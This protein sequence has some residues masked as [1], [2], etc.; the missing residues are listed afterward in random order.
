MQEIHADISLRDL[1]LILRRGFPLI[2]VAA[3]LAGAAAFVITSILPKS[4]RSTSVVQVIP[5]PIGEQQIGGL[6]FNPR[7]NLSFEAYRSIA[8]DTKVLQQTLDTLEGSDLG[9]SGLK[10]RIELRRLAG[11]DNP[12]QIAPLAVEHLVSDEDPD[13]VLRIASAWSQASLD[14]VRATLTASL[15]AMADTTSQ[16]LQRRQRA[17]DEG[18][19]AWQAFQAGDNRDAIR[20]RLADVNTRFT[21]SSARIDQLGRLIAV[22]RARQAFLADQ[23]E[24][25]TPGT[26]LDTGAQLSA[27]VENR[28]LSSEVATQLRVLLAEQPDFAQDAEQ[29]LLLLLLRAE[30]QQVTTA[31]V[32]QLAERDFILGEAA[33]LE[34]QAETL[35]A[36]LA[37][38]ER[39]A[40]TLERELE[41]ARMAYQSV[42]DIAPVIEYAGELVS[43]SAS[44]LSAPNVAPDSI[45]RGRM[46]NTVVSALLAAVLAVLYLFLR[47]AIRDPEARA[48]LRQSAAP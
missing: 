41:A 31:L 44:L 42:V 20:L 32:G 43:T 13:L 29:D 35:R 6:D 38:L 4:Y 15:T 16:A 26:A 19:A 21:E 11:P 8:L 36:R 40:T 47:E 10:Q 46:A 25:A 30:L 23:L 45:G 24:A 33:A 7:S 27:L 17:V 39:E 14:A 18:E 3:L 28:L 12:N 22:A 34:A 9:L 2:A 48:D 37:E 5:S 1:Y